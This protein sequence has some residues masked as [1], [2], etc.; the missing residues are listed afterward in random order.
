MEKKLSLGDDCTLIRLDENM[1]I[2]LLSCRDAD[3]DDFFHNEALLYSEQLLGKTY[4]VVTNEPPY[5]PV[6]MITLSNDSI[7][8]ALIPNTSRNRIQ[9]KIPNSKRT[10][11]YPAALIGRIGVAEEYKGMELGSQIINYL[12]YLFTRKENLTGCR[13]LVVD[14]YND[15]RVL[16]FYI[17]NGFTPLYA[18]EDLEREAFHIA[19]GEKLHSRMLYF[20]LMQSTDK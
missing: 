1:D 10:R 6:A 19:E 9:R 14:A 2:S 20:D 15:D 5:K 7:K 11:S 8:S 12:K 4:V 17:K 13:F 3:L 16:G 18:N